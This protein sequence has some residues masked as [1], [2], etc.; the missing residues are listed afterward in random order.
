MREKIMAKI[1]MVIIH[2]S[3]LIQGIRMS[4][5]LTASTMG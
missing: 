5:L 2:G 3:T 4:R 1:P